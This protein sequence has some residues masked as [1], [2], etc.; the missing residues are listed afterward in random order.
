MDLILNAKFPELFD[1]VYL[2]IYIYVL[3]SVCACVMSSPLF[4]TIKSGEW[5][6]TASDKTLTDELR[7]CLIS[8]HIIYYHLN[9]LFYELFSFGECVS[10]DSMIAF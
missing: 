5:R 10:S 2:Y 3:W 6:S 4:S 7:L 8:I 1:R 9:E